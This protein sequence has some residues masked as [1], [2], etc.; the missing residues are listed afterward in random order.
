M[1]LLGLLILLGIFAGCDPYGFGFKKN[2]AYV[3]NEAFQAVLNSQTNNDLDRNENIK[4]FLSATG[5]E[6]YC[7]YGNQAGLTYLYNNLNI[8]PKE[9]EIIPRIISNY[10]KHTPTP[11]FSTSF[12]SYYQE[13]YKLEI[14]HAVTREDL[15]SVIVDCHYGFAGQKR[16]EH[17]KVMSKQ[18]YKMKEC[19]VVKMVP[20]KFKA[21]PMTSLCMPLKIDL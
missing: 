17:A 6:A 12:W 8:D 19:R 3:L 5:K 7:L 16:P 11:I 18:K 10:T 4:A 2:P 1:K 9:V 13:R 15:F 14:L 21:L 20:M